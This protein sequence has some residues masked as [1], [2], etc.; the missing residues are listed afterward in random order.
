MVDTIKGRLNITIPL[1]DRV[2][3]PIKIAGQINRLDLNHS[4]NGYDV[5]LFRSTGYEGWQNELRMALIQ[6]CISQKMHTPSQMINVGVYSF[7]EEYFE[8]T[9][10]SKE[11]IEK[12]RRQLDIFLGKMGI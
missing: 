1:P 4:T 5:W 10:Y 12:A 11:V 9:S 3:E 2:L 8:S 7:E 6:H